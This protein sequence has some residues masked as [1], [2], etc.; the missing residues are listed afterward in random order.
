MQ[1]V[2]VSGYLGRD[3][4]MRYTPQGK[5][6][7][8]FSVPVDLGTK[9]KPNTVWHRCTAWGKQA[10]TV[11]QYFKKGDWIE[12]EGTVTASAFTSRE[13]EPKANLEVNVREF[14]FGPKGKNHTGDE[15][16]AEPARASS[17]GNGSVPDED[18]LPF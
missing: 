2:I 7:T 8:S 18:D 12:V 4:E 5:E 16:E 3:P 11:A 10:V 13:G 15:S 1:K 9:E 14:H 6:V 17:N